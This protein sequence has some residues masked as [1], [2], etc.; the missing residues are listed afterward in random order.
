[1][2][3]LG[4]GGWETH[5]FSSETV[6]ETEFHGESGV[7][8]GLPIPDFGMNR[9][10][11]ILDVA[12]ALRVSLREARDIA[13]AAEPGFNPENVNLGACIREK[14]SR[15]VKSLLTESDEEEANC[16]PPFWRQ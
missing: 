6:F 9:P 2:S 14:E 12:A 11:D 8:E 10:Y 3:R 16:P 4:H 15:R 5:F 13:Q 7:G 1:M